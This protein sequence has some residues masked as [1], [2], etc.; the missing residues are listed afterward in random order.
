MLLLRVRARLQQI[1][2]LYHITVHVCVI[3][4]LQ[5]SQSVYVCLFVQ[6]RLLENNSSANNKQYWSSE[7]FIL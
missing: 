4:T 6:L 7:Q 2:C 5:E 1:P 3:K